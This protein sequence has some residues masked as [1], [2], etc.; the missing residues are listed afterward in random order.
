MSLPI[1][2]STEFEAKI[3]TILDQSDIAAELSRLVVAPC[4]YRGVGVSRLL[5]RS[6]IATTLSLQKN[7]LLLECIPAHVK[8]YQDHGFESASRARTRAEDLDQEAVAMY[9]DAKAESPNSR[10]RGLAENDLKTL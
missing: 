9:L 7:L 3:K 4:R 8:M 6:V 10:F 2:Q 1:L 5:V